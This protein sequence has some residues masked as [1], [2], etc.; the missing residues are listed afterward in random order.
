MIIC[1][2]SILVIALIIVLII[3][4]PSNNNKTKEDK[5]EARLQEL[6][7][8]Y[9]KVYYNL[10]EE[11]ER[12]KFLSN[13]TT[14]GIKANLEN[15]A[16]TVAGTDGLSTKEEILKEFSKCSLAKTKVIV[17]PQEP[18]GEK[19]YKLKVSLKCGK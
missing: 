12:A 1:I 10:I 19:D 11:K 8:T 18:F 13:Y 7:N 16:K 5:L 14:L 3:K 9:Y 2:A 6:G 15:L 17:Y 4:L